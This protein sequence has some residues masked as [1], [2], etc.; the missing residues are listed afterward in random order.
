M[1]GSAQPTQPRQ[2]TRRQGLW[3]ADSWHPLTGLLLRPA[4]TTNRHRIGPILG[5][6]ARNASLDADRRP[7]CRIVGDTTHPGTACQ[8]RGADPRSGA[9]I[10]RGADPRSG[11]G[12]C[13][14]R[15]PAVRARELF[16]ARDLRHRHGPEP[17]VGREP[18]AS[19]RPPRRR[20]SGSAK[21]CPG[22]DLN[23]DELPHTPLK[24]TRIPIPP[25]GQVSPFVGPR[26]WYRGRDSNPHDL[27][28]TGT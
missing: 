15:G 19:K 24:R 4:A 9:G 6:H 12:N 26:E 10:V 25:P 14:W 3:N 18:A 20:S 1:P 8:V 21:W 27:A 2:P 5:K 17:R 16:V 22:R 11:R 23:P 13:S 28:A 7:I